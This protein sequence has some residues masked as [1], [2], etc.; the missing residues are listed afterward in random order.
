MSVVA[1]VTD[2]K[3][4][5]TFEDGWNPHPVTG[6]NLEYRIFLPTQE[7]ELTSPP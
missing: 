5:P 7:P 2:G 1:E 4:L 3:P 6:G